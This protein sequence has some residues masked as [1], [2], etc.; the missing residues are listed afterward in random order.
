LLSVRSH[1]S[2]QII[3]RIAYTG[4]FSIQFGNSLN[5]NYCTV[6][7]VT[8]R[9]DANRVLSVTAK[10]KNS[11]LQYEWLQNG[12]MMARTHGNMVQEVHSMD[13]P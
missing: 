9:V 3:T 2:A 12:H 6:M 4:L 13:K 8:F 5:Y 10:E 1:K 11:Q 7:Q